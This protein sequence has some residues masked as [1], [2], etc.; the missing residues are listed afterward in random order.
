MENAAMAPPVAIEHASGLPIRRANSAQ[1]I[2][3]RSWPARAAGRVG[4]GGL[5]GLVLLDV[6]AGETPLRLVLWVAAVWLAGAG[7]RLKAG[8]YRFDQ[9]LNAAQVVDKIARGDVYVRLITF[10]EG[11]T[12]REMARI[13]ESKGFGSAQAF[14]RVASDA[15]AISDLDPKAPDLEG[16]LFPDTY[17]F[18]R[19]V[20]APAVLQAMTDVKTLVDRGSFCTKYA[21]VGYDVGGGDKVEAHHVRA[22]RSGP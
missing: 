16:Y 22:A 18:A 9:P 8:E 5:I 2:P 12:I 11:L 10:P 20:G 21:S 14:V 1:P 7:R 15:S 4:Q 17:R 6:V 13:F 19:N 3:Q